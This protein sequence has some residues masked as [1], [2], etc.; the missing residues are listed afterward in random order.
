MTIIHTE[1]STGWGG[2]EIRIWHEARWFRER[3]HRVVLCARPDGQIGERFREDN[4]EVIPTPF[5]G[6]TRCLDLFR[7]RRVFR[8]VRPDMVGTHSSLDSWAGLVA[9]RL[10][11]VQARFRYRHISAPVRAGWPN[12]F[13]YGKAANQVLTTAEC[14]RLDLVRGLGLDRSRVAT[15]P[16]GIAPPVFETT[17]EAERAALCRR[18][19]LPGATRFIGCVAVLRS[20]KGHEYLMAA[21]DK[22]AERFP[23]HC[24]VVVGDGPQRK[25]LEEER[26]KSRHGERM[27]LVGHQPNAWPFFRAFDMAV[28][29]SYKDEGIPQSLLQAMF[30]E[31]PVVGTRAG[32]IPEIVH[33]GITG[34]VVEPRDPEG[35]GKA[36]AYCL[37][38]PDEAVARSVAAHRMVEQNHT[39][40]LMG[41][42]A[43]GLIERRQKGRAGR[44]VEFGEAERVGY[45]EKLER[46]C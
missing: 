37:K 32:G 26:Q 42:R 9:A 29:A 40:D 10:A 20:W 27:R 2:Q 43:L 31:C 11:G 25:R 16:T 6:S 13:L 46:R 19:D 36:M 4:F 1:A 30:A 15:V 22:L 39:L 18:L 45:L 5:R 38:A 14:I 34:L 33:E 8:R 41:R 21:F 24:L 17:R 28:L 23:G 35:L 7:L 44:V 12:R 3:G